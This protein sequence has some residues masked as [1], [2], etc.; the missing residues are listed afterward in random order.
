M[1][2]AVRRQQRYDHRLRELVRRTGELRLAT[3]R[4]VPRS[5][6]RGWLGGSSSA[7]VSLNEAERTEAELRQEI[8]TLQRRVTKLAALLR[9]ALALGPRGQRRFTRERL[10]DGPDKARLLR[11]IEGPAHPSH[12]EGS[13]GFC[14]C[15]RADCTPG[16]AGSVRVRSRISGRAPGCRRTA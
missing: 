15:R 2:T 8:L 11:A 10:L 1:T 5:T 4:G 13:C 16:A 7:V 3:G 9:L 14:V 6:A 12:C